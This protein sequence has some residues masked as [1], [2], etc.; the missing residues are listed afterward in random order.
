MPHRAVLHGEPSWVLT[1]TWSRSWLQR[2]SVRRAGP[3]RFG[4][5]DS[6]PARRT[7]PTSA[8][9]DA[10]GPVRPPGPH[11]HHVLRSGLGWAD[12][13]AAGRRA[14]DR[15]ARAV[16]ATR[17]SH[18]RRRMSSAFLAWQEF[19]RTADVFPVGAIVAGG[20]TTTLTPRS[21]PGTTPFPDETSPRGPCLPS[22]VPTSPDDPVSAANRAAWASRPLRAA[23]PVRLQ[24]RR[25][26]HQAAMRSSTGGPGTA[27]QAHTTIEGGGHFLQEDRGAELAAVLIG[28]LSGRP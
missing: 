5:S 7:T 25:P 8:R 12:R 2:A 13:P 28:F 18:R 21:S 26:H 1:G 10:P 20:C 4:R 17:A 3:G 15:Y 24:R 19:A 23:V 14:P 22:L 9:S 11:R 27:G 16:V 6:R